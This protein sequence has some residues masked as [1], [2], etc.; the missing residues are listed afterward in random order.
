[1]DRHLLLI[2]EKLEH[3]RSCPSGDPGPFR[4]EY[5]QYPSRS[6]SIDNHIHFRSRIKININ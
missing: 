6:K 1:M 5:E 2:S 4:R 3:G